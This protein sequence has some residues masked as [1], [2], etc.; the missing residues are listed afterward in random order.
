MGLYQ[1][2][3][4]EA[5]LNALGLEVWADLTETRYGDPTGI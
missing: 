5:E 3:Q 2:I 4:F 1:D